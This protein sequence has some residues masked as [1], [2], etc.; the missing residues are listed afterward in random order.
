MA[1]WQQEHVQTCFN[2]ISRM[3]LA[4]FH[5]DARNRGVGFV[6]AK[7]I[8]YNDPKNGKQEDPAN[9]GPI[10]VLR[11]SY[12]IFS[13]LVHERLQHI[14]ADHL[15]GPKGLW[16]QTFG[17]RCALDFWAGK[18]IE[19][20]IPVWMAPLD[21][22]KAPDRVEY[23]AFVEAPLTQ[24]VPPEQLAAL[25]EMYRGQSRHLRGAKGFQIGRGVKQGDVISPF[26]FNA[27][28]DFAIRS[29]KEKVSNVGPMRPVGTVGSAK[30]VARTTA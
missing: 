9:W 21:L 11:I 26:L 1:D 8:V 22:K 27:S 6:M 17:G 29:W 25:A 13:R 10:A 23:N 4:G 30:A 12:R 2:R 19:W 5:S 20:N 7:D 16:T 24:G 15:A 18:S 28:L 14:L 3:S